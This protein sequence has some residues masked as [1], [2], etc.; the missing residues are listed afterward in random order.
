[1]PEKRDARRTSL[2]FCTLFL[3]FSSSVTLAFLL[4]WKLRAYV[5]NYHRADV[6]ARAWYLADRLLDE[7]SVSAAE[8]QSESYQG[9]LWRLRSLSSKLTWDKCLSPMKRDER[10]IAHRG[11]PLMFPEHTLEG[12]TSAVRMGAGMLEC[13][14][15]FTRDRVAVCRHSACDL[16]YTT[17]ILRVPALADKCDKKFQPGEGARCC[18]TDLL[19]SE[20]KQLCGTMEDGG[21]ATVMTQKEYIQLS[22]GREMKVK[23]IPELKEHDYSK[24]DIHSQ[25]E[26]A[27]RFI[28]DYLDLGVPPSLLFPQTFSKQHATRWLS[29]YPI[30]KN[31]VLLY[32]PGGQE[33]NGKDTWETTYKGWFEELQRLGQPIK[34]AGLPLNEVISANDAL[35]GSFSPTE[36]VRYLKEQGIEIIVWTLERSGAVPSGWYLG[37][38]QGNA[39]T[40]T[41]GNV[42]S[43]VRKDADIY[44][45]LDVLFKEVGVYGVFSD[46]PGTVTHYLNCAL[47]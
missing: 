29:K 10:S 21:C 2:S 30:A 27:D 40:G 12:Y 38:Q 25:D 42:Q 41:H 17:N 7:S 46:W 31:T 33:Q 9:R 4:G 16:H 19:A 1:M 34:F 11:A 18:T 23:M 28:Q 44:L 15:V 22:M 36:P 20:Y 45:L 13:D 14:A 8:L 32:S 3:F 43:A 47:P 37:V 39:S 26:A 35:G 6:G 24:I 5:F